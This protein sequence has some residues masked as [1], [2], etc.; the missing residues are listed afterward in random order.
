M[1][2]IEI[3]EHFKITGKVL[4]LN[5]LII[6]SFIFNKKDPTLGS[7]VFEQAEALHRY[8]HTVYLAFCDTYSVKEVKRWFHYE[9]HQEEKNGIFIYRS[10]AFCP[11]KRRS[12]FLG[13]R[14]RFSKE[15][16]QI[17]EAYLADKQIDII[18]AHCCAWA[19]YAAMN[20][21]KK[22]GIPYVITEHSSLYRLHSDWIKEK[23]KKDIKR[24]FA[25]AK[26][27]ICVSGALQKM[28]KSYCEESQIL[29]NVIDCSLFSPIPELQ[30]KENVTF[31]T[32]FYMK[33]YQQFLNKGIDLLLESFSEVIKEFPHARLLIGG[34]GAGKQQLVEWIR[35]KN[36]SEKVTMLG[37]L[38]RQEVAQQMQQC[39]VF[40]LPSRYETFGVVYAEAMACGKPVI[41]TRTGGPDSF[42]TEETGIMIDVE[43]QAQLS[44][45]MLFMV[46][47]HKKYDSQKIRTHIENLFS[48]EAVARQLDEIYREIV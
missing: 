47:N 44:Q 7:F 17:Y 26:A 16:I 27:V 48:M 8:G 4:N 37:A 10:K 31:L 1:K 46:E 3:D 9:E 30:K 33:H 29:G 2:E 6:P 13:C 11:L 40:V 42:V 25:G 36:L 15:I 38:S 18:H 23:Y 43:N 28:I 21:S 35:D 45:A 5:I 14:K 22:T 32:V 39:D 12:G 19:G 41:A 34:D 20:L 24:A